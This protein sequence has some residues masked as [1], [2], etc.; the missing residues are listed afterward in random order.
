MTDSNQ[1]DDRYNEILKKIAARKP[2][3]AESQSAQ[4]SPLDLILDYLN[5]YDTL[6]ALAQG[7]YSTILCYGPQVM[8]GDSWVGVLIWSHA[9]SYYG[10]RTLSLLGI[11]TQQIET[12]LQVVLGLRDLPYKAPVFS[13]E[14]YHSLIR[15]GFKTFYEDNG[16]PPQAS[17]Y[18]LYQVI[19]EQKNRLLMREAI[20]THLKQWKAN[21]G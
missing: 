19:Y 11:W 17:D 12:D 7:T 9:K 16:H 3:G 13:A 8:R 20:Q 10:Y 15:R 14:A 1:N 18:V 6:D 2:F 5:A 21:M 4:G